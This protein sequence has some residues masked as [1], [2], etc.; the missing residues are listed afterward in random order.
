MLRHWQQDPDLAGVRDAAELEKLPEAE[1]AEW[2]K[3]WEDVAALLKKCGESGAS[4][5][6]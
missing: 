4:R 2:K 6:K 3:L 1:R 5:R